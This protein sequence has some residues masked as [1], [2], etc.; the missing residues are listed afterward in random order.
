MIAPKGIHMLALICL[1]AA[2]I[3]APNP[4]PVKGFTLLILICAAWIVASK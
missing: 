1:M 3:H 2:A 4:T